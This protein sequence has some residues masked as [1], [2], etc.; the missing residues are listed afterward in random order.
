[1]SS[2]ELDTRLCQREDVKDLRLPHLDPNRTI[3][4]RSS[5][6]LISSYGRRRW[7]SLPNP[8]EPNR[9]RPKLLHGPA[10]PQDRDSVDLVDPGEFTRSRSSG[11]WSRIHQIA[12]YLVDLYLDQSA[13]DALDHSHVPSTYTDLPYTSG[14]RGSRRSHLTLQGV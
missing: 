13:T 7:M 9:T 5:S 6:H 4:Q 8:D 1:M 12:I 10:L 3:T 14:K 2:D 11:S